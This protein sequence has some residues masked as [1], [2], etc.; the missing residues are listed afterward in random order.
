MTESLFTEYLSWD[1][2]LATQVGF[3]KYDHKLRDPTRRA[4][5]HQ[6]ERL[7]EFISRLSGL[8]ADGMTD[9]QALDREFALH[10]FRLRRFEIE[11]LRRHEKAS[12]AATELGNS[13]FLL[14]MRERPSVDVRLE[15]IA[16]RMEAAPQFLERS[17]ETL[18][19]PYRR[20]NEI[21]LE[22]GER[23]PRFL[24]ELQEDFATRPVGRDA[25]QRL[26]KAVR[27][28]TS[29]LEE[30]NRWMRTDIIPRSSGEVS[31]AG[32]DLYREYLRLQA[33][34]VTLEEALSIGQLCLDRVNAQK[35]DLALKIVGNANVPDAV[36][37]MRAD[38]ASDF[39]GVLKE[40]RESVL[41]ARGFVQDRGLVTIPEGERLVVVP[42]P[43]YM[44]HVV[45]YAAQYE[46][47]KY[48]E[49]MTGHFFVTPDQDN[50]ATLEE[51]NHAAVVNTAVHEGYPGHHL[52]GI[53]ANKNPSRLRA[54]Y[55]S[56]DFAEGWGLYC[57][58]MMLS[59]GYCDSPLGRLTVLN[60]L[61]FRIARQICDVKIAIGEMSIEQAA[62][63]L[64]KE[65]GT[66]AQAAIS[67]AKAMTLAPTYYVSY[68]IG[69]LGVLQMLDDAKALLG[70][71]FGL[72]FF[73]DS[74]IYAGCM[75]MPFMRRALALRIRDKFELELG[76]PR[77]SVFEY[78][79]RTMPSRIA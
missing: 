50:P 8:S 1:P 28:A 51:H 48:D 77:E 38:H 20:W 3:H 18:T 10:L 78:A 32:R 70:E 43:S 7:S 44:A 57:E 25:L 27:E 66:D 12:F 9:D 5:G 73:H 40:Y 69:K 62:E 76:P 47:G 30:H 13:L 75:P 17:R 29:A 68:F 79:L 56:P 45:P 61:G 74:L 54:L 64:A 4:Y 26:A 34:G 60:D 23:M 42:T 55:S 59:Q 31:G 71:R 46:P 41:K 15:A 49:D 53:C 39:D 11:S 2:A 58:E 14:F 33:F 19:R 63:F 72:R 6:A 36:A 52:H 35:A 24:K 37:M 16:A 67:E 65:S 22:T 21:L